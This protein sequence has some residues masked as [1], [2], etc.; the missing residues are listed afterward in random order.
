MSTYDIIVQIIGFIG[1][2][3]SVIAFQCKKHKN[4]MINKTIN[5]MIFALQYF[6]L[7]AYTGVAMNLIGSARNILFAKLIEKGKSTTVAQIIFG[8]FF[9]IFGIFTWQGPISI[10]VISAKI[11]TSIAY[12]IKNTSV[13]RWLTLPTSVCWLIYNTVSM[14]F[15]GILCESFTIISI[16]SAIIRIDFLKK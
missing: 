12:G 5:E 2:I 3:F 9:V 10:M 15:A 11:V 8:V 14:S 6:M 13:L 1:L 4:V 7:G 16:V